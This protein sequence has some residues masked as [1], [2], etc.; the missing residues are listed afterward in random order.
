MKVGTI[1]LSDKLL[2]NLLHIDNAVILGAKRA[3]T[4]DATEITIIHPKLPDLCE[5]CYPPYISLEDIAEEESE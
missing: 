3:D 2:K 5:G 4:F 1:R